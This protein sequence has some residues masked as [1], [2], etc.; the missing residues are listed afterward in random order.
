M[1]I[2]HVT[3]TFMPY[4]SGTGVVCYQNAMGLAERGHEV[5]VY[6]SNHPAGDYTYPD[7][8][9]VHRLPITFRVGNAPFLPGLIKL[10][11]YD[12]VHLHFPFI[13]GQEILYFK[14]LL[15]GMPYVITYHQDVIL[16]G[17]IGT[18]VK[19]HHFFLGRLILARAKRLMVTSHDY[20]QSGR[21]APLVNA[22]KERVV[23][24]PNGVDPDR[25]NP[26]V[27]GEALR[28][29]YGLKPEDRVVLFVGGLD[30]PHYFKGVE[31]LLKSFTHIPDE[32]AKLL[33][34]GDGDLRPHYTTLAE[35]LGIKDRVI[36]CG[37]VSDELLPAHYA[38]CDLHVL[39]SVTMGEAFGIVLL[40]AMACA[41]PVLATN[42]PGVRSVVADGDDGFLVPPND[43]QQLA[44]KIQHL[45]DH[46]SQRA[47]MGQKGR[48]KVENKYAWPRVI[49]R[50]ESVYQEVLDER[51]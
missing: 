24:I 14:S 1:K 4:H 16:K 22:I 38:L 18:A 36:F 11:G 40:E 17:A 10:K 47:E 37:R 8:I 6:T 32:D 41:K 46:P 39:P 7:A 51:H 30:T 13:F 23:D 25:F 15:R 21:I 45:L 2:A 42:L 26:Q 19:L 44:N 50:L 35:N 20:A 48:A 5:A 43:H 28:E 33:I 49:D 29:T 31:V 27:N 9:T 3:A 12:L 34:V